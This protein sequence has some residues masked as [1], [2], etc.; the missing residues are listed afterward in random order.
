MMTFWRHR[1]L[2]IAITFAVAPPAYAQNKIAVATSIGNDCLPAWIAKEKGFN[3]QGDFDF[4][5]TLTQA[6]AADLGALLYANSAQIAEMTAIS[7]ALANENGLDLVIVAGAGI[8]TEVNPRQVLVR[9]A[10]TIKSPGDFIGKKVG[11]PGLNGAL[12]IMFKNW[13]KVEGVDPNGVTYIETGFSRMAD[14]L[15]VGQVDAVLPV[16]PF[17]SRIIQAGAGLPAGDYF[18]SVNKVTLLSFYVSTRQWAE[19]NTS[20]L[21]AFRTILK[22]GDAFIQANPGE[23]RSIE[24]KDLKLSSEIAATLPFTA[25]DVNVPAARLQF[26]LD[27]GH[28]F[29]ITKER[30]D[31]ANFIAK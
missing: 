29:G 20:A 4:E 6:G 7:F 13:L 23:A 27:I 12:Q 19:A 31:A 9:P 24:A 18:T 11:V 17:A 30:P 14:L 26:W 15:K 25:T 5:V 22:Q 21:A 10:A 3:I 2:W 16:E 1:I 8:Q 28:E